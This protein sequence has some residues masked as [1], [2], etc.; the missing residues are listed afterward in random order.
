MAMGLTGAR[1]SVRSVKKNFNC[2][3]RAV[4][5]RPAGEDC[6]QGGGEGVRLARL[7]VFVAEESAVAAGEGHGTR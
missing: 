7:A 6:A 4:V 3:G 1:T 2:L 5:L